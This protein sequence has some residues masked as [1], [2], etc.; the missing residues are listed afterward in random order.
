[1]SDEYSDFRTPKEKKTKAHRKAIQETSAKLRMER[2]REWSA[3]GL[4]HVELVSEQPLLE[5]IR[6]GYLGRGHSVRWR[7]WHALSPLLEGRIGWVSAG[8]VVK[9][10]SSRDRRRGSTGT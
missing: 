7:S 5:S 4:V 8:L 2:E 1:M 10:E 3:K 9:P 6:G